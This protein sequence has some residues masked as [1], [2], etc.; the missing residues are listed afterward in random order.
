[1][2]EVLQFAEGGKGEVMQMH[3]VL[4]RFG[5]CATPES[6]PQPCAPQKLI[7]L[8]MSGNIMDHGCLNNSS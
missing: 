7:R 1:M 6:N 4:S 3:K 2:G 5:S 8:R